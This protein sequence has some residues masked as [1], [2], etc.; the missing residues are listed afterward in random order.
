MVR[1]FRQGQEFDLAIELRASNKT[2]EQVF[3]ELRGVLP[4]TPDDEEPCDA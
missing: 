1:I 4:E 3:D 2:P